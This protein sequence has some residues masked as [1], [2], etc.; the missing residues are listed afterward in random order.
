MSDMKR[1]GLIF[2]IIGIFL[3]L[4][5]PGFSFSPALCRVPVYY[6]ICCSEYT[7][8]VLWEDLGAP[9]GS[10]I[11]CGGLPYP[12]LTEC[13]YSYLLTLAHNLYYNGTN[14]RTNW[15][16][17][18]QP[19]CRVESLK[20]GGL[21]EI[22]G[23]FGRCRALLPYLPAFVSLGDKVYESYPSNFWI[24]EKKGE[25][26]MWYHHWKENA[27]QVFLRVEDGYAYDAKGNPVR[28]YR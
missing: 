1:N 7:G 22:S 21:C 4:F 28:T 5:Q 10:G 18:G 16:D 3:L 11:C 24:C 15:V 25:K 14:Y 8:E 2:A 6:G 9:P 19:G 13:P 20:P 23:Q 27:V 12:G 17:A 26:V